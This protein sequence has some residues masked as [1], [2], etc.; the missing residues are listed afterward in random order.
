MAAGRYTPLHPQNP[1][2]IKIGKDKMKFKSGSEHLYRRLTVRESARIQTFPDD[3]LFV[4]DDIDAG[5][6]MVENAVSV[7][8]TEHIAKE[9]R[10]TLEQ[11]GIG[12]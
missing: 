4:Y 7:K 6:K 9:I 8:L 3:Y 12:T 11:I 5:Y 1:P 10:R 2:M